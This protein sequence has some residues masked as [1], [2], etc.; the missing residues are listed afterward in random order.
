MGD[1][2]TTSTAAPRRRL[3]PLQVV[4]RLQAETDLEEANLDTSQRLYADYLEDEVHDDDAPVLSDFEGDL[5][6]GVY[7]S[8]T[9]F[10]KEEFDILWDTLRHDVL[11]A[12]QRGKGRKHKTTAKDAFFMTICVLKHCNSWYKHAADF[13]LQPSAFERMVDKMLGVIEPVVTSLYIVKPTGMGYQKFDNFPYALYA[14]DVKFQQSQSNR[15]GGTFL[16]AKKYFSGKH[17]LYGLK[18][19]CSVGPDGR[20]VD[21]TKHYAGSVTDAAIFTENLDTHRQMLLKTDADR[22]LPQGDFQEGASRFPDHWAVLVDKGYQ[23]MGAHVR[24]IQPKKQPAH[25]SLSADDV[26]RNRLVSHDRVIIENFFGRVNML[27]RVMYKK[28]TWKE[29]RYDQLVRVCFALTNFHISLS[30]LRAADREVY[31]ATLAKYASQAYDR[32]ERR[33]QQHLESLQRRRERQEDGQGVTANVRRTVTAQTPVYGARGNFRAS[34]Y[35]GQVTR[36]ISQRMGQASP[37]GLVFEE[38]QGY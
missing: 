27:W 4:D 36:A 16:D 2:S 17:H 26:D 10:S 28:Y 14:T 15:P 9:N 23:G 19:E 37:T 24:T 22:L 33:R 13:R 20:A 5:G 25:G 35:G 30:P 7:H 1:V 21:V 29:E 6:E 12:W 32:V 34:P 31:R 18:V 38:S 3:Q 11:F 8:M